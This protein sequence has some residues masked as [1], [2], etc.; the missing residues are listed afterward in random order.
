MNLLV[1]VNFQNLI[2]VVSGGGGGGGGGGGELKLIKSFGWDYKLMFPHMQ[3]DQMCIIKITSLVHVVVA[4]SM[5]KSGG[6]WKLK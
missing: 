2:V 5:S 4:Q 1:E 6:L 3:K